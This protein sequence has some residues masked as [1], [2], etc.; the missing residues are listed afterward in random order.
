MIEAERK[1][2]LREVLNLLRETSTIVAKCGKNLGG[3]HCNRSTRRGYLADVW[4]GVVP[5]F[6]GVL[7]QLHLGQPRQ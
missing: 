3:S 1:N 6:V 2:I 4:E 7:V 5:S